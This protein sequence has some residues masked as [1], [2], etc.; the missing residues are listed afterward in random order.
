MKKSILKL[1]VVA[2]C[3]LGYAHGTVLYYI[4]APCEQSGVDTVASCSAVAFCMPGDPSFLMAM[5]AS[6][7]S[8]CPGNP[9]VNSAVI[10]VDEISLAGDSASVLIANMETIIYNHGY[11]DCGGTSSSYG[12]NIGCP[13]FV[14]PPSGPIGPPRAGQGY[15]DDG[16]ECFNGFCQN[17]DTCTTESDGGDD[18]GSGVCYDVADACYGYQPCCGEDGGCDYCQSNYQFDGNCGGYKNSSYCPPIAN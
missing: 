8:L 9:V 2:I 13:Y 11:T 18:G 15:C 17:G 3:S 7:G 14:P 16:S 6:A 1:C 5:N 10:T 12:E 4:G